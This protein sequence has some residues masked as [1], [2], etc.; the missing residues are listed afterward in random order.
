MRVPVC[1]QNGSTINLR[2][3][4]GKKD[5]GKF[6]AKI[7][8]RKQENRMREASGKT[9]SYSSNSKNEADSS[10]SAEKIISGGRRNWLIVGMIALVALGALGASLKYL[11]DD[12]RRQTANGGFEFR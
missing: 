4:R 5:T 1:P 7:K 2:S 3:L 6:M 11:E 10:A 9:G 12:A 8:I